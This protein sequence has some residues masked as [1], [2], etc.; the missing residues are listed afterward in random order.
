MR[1]H[2]VFRMSPVILIAS[3]LSSCSGT[4][5]LDPAGP[6]AGR[7]TDLFS[8]MVV[9][10]T[11]VFVLVMAT[12]AY[13]I[14]KGRRRN[15]VATEPRDAGKITTSISIAVTAT[16]I[17]LF[18]LL[19][20]SIYTGR[21]LTSKSEENAL[22]ISVVG[23][24]W[25]WEVQYESDEPARTLKTA[26][27]I[28]IP[29][30]RLISLKLTSHDVIHSFW[31]PNLT[32]KRDLIPGHQTALFFTADR[33]GLFSGRCAEFC[34]HQHAHMAFDVIVQTPDEFAEWYEHQLEPAQT[35]TGDAELT[36]QRIFLSTRCVMCHT[37]AGTG[38]GAS[39]GPDLTHISSR[40][41]IAA[42]ALTNTSEHLESWVKDSQAVKPG[43]KMPRIDIP[44]DQINA[45]VAYLETLK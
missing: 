25:W 44:Q 9:V 45:V 39:V 7:I 22:K 1:S 29:A 5:S 38:A 35:P 13:S 4:Q 6:A 23:H 17:T 16:V 28:H 31:A 37:V 34:G 43:N 41:C 26:N 12:L 27:E 19:I 15:E 36:G 42:G 11:V 30:G 18:V 33:T 24:Q 3:L 10:S 20:A 40:R 32:G 14:S 21:A 2:T 8:L